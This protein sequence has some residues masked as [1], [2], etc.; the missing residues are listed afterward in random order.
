MIHYKITPI[1]PHA[2]LF[3]VTM[4][5]KQPSCKQELSLPA[6]LPGS[7]MIRDFAK[8]IISITAMDNDNQALTLNQLD[9]QRWLINTNGEKVI[10]RYQ[11]YSWD[12]SVRTA[13][14]DATRGFFNGSSVFLAAKGL[15][16]ALHTIDILPS[17]HP[18]CD[19]W[20]LATTLT[21]Y[22]GDDYGYGTFQADS[23]AE[24]IDHPVE[25]GDFTV[26]SFNAKGVQ[27][28]VVLAGKHRACMNRL[29]QD[30]KAICE[31]QIDL[32]G[33]P[34][35]FKRYLFMTAV[36]DSGFG[37]LEHRSSTALMCSR[38]DLPLTMDTKVEQ[39]YRTYLSLCSHE[40]FHSWNIKRIKP[41][42]F[43]SYQLET[44]SY[45]QQ[46]WAYEGITSYYDDFITYRSG[47]V[48][49]K[50]Y[51]TMLAELITR[52][53]RGQGRFKQSLK[54]SS[55]NTW[56]KF[57]Q[58]DENAQNA[59]VSYYTKG[60]MF[61]L[62]LDLTIRHETQGQHSLDDVMRSLWQ[63]YGLI[64]RGTDDNSHQ[65]IIESLLNRN[66]DDLFAY[67]DNTDDLPLVA[68]FEH[69]GV[70]M[71]LRSSS[72]NTDF[73]GELKEGLAIGFGAK[74]KA[75]HLGLTII[76]V[77]ENSP[78]MAAGLSAGDNLIAIDGLK[79]NDNIEKMLQQFTIGESV[80][81]VWFRRDELMLGMLPIKA[82]ELDTVSLSVTDEILVKNWLG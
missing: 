36:L 24:L 12:L 59:I 19:N 46:L 78:A 64:E 34:A 52:V 54:E 75:T 44:E 8:N 60:A 31:H 63:N 57:Y 28:D 32:F 55:F 22:S 71:T 30:L 40:Y 47:R 62:L 68:M 41:A 70:K 9:K 13:Y 26:A 79:A 10:I 50:Q 72:G 66:C 76:S 17:F 2:H 39:G 11:I 53:Y 43:I 51:L 67:I 27:H 4:T 80:E 1:N 15:E 74:Y 73:G 21:R 56:T 61:A 42:N 35:P 20:K 16:Q 14:L 23:Y 33:T 69:F 81:L 65:Q 6:W 5:I 49:Q 48:T 18:A 38:G 58:Q 3:D 45:T 37:G 82:A 77:T 25:M 7:Y 29:C